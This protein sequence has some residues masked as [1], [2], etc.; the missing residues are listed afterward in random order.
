MNKVETKAEVRLDLR[1]HGISPSAINE[2]RRSERSRLVVR[3]GTWLLAVSSSRH[4]TQN[5]NLRDAI[6]K[7]NQI[8]EAAAKRAAPP[9]PPSAEKKKRMRTLSNREN[10]NRLQAK[11]QRSDKKKGRR[12]P[13]LDD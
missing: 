4:R 10:R 2:L 13:Q 6:A 3:D 7:T 5:M 11:K 9:P 8:L 1:R 12:K